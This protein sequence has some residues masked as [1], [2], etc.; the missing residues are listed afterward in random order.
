[1]CEHE[2]GFA[3]LRPASRA[4]ELPG[5]RVEGD[6]LVGRLVAE[7][8]EE[9]ALGGAL[10]LDRRLGDHPCHGRILVLA[11][12]VVQGAL[13]KATSSEAILP[14]ASMCGIRAIP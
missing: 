5:D 2:V 8:L 14:F 6:E 7:A 10:G 3:L 11:R 9:P 13:G 1:M 12:R 4:G